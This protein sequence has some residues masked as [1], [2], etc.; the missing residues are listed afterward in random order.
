[1]CEPNE[2]LIL[3]IC[4]VQIFGPH[5]AWTL[6]EDVRQMT[7]KLNIFRVNLNSSDACSCWWFVKEKLMMMSSHVHLRKTFKLPCWW[8]SRTLTLMIRS[9]LLDR[10]CSFLRQPPKNFVTLYTQW[11]LIVNMSHQVKVVTFH[12]VITSNCL[13]VVSRPRHSVTRAL[14]LSYQT[15]FL[16]K[17]TI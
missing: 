12:N 14:S 13:V 9:Y 3:L 15:V 8:M 1:M 7:N 11:T 16:L 6:L 17:V 10:F 4:V 2:I 5:T